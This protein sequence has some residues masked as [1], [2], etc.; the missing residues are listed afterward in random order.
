MMI[1]N[2]FGSVLYYGNRDR[3]LRTLCQYTMEEF[4]CDGS[5]AVSCRVTLYNLHRLQTPLLF[6]T[7]HRTIGLKFWN[8]KRDK[9]LADATFLEALSC[10]PSLAEIIATFNR[11]R[12][13]SFSSYELKNMPT[14]LRP[15][16]L[17]LLNLFTTQ[18]DWPPYPCARLELERPCSTSRANLG[19]SQPRGR[20]QYWPLFFGSGPSWLHGKCSNTC[21]VTSLLFCSALCLGEV[22]MT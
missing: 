8:H 10:L 16:L 19:I 15:Y 12:M 11:R 3:P 17:N 5:K 4:P 22:P 13:D 2:L 14:Q 18:A 1:C 20:L 9:G 7:R 21:K 6:F